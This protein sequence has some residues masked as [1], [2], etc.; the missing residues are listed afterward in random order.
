MADS[1]CEEE[2]GVKVELLGASTWLG[3]GYNDGV[4]GGGEGGTR[5]L[6]CVRG[7]L[8]PCPDAT[9]KVTLAHEHQFSRFLKNLFLRFQK[10]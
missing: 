10:N 2:R 3:E 5:N 9:R 6:H 1:S 4:S 7:L 8:C